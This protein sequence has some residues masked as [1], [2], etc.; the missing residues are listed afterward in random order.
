VTERTPVP[1]EHAVPRLRRLVLLVLAGVLG[2]LALTSGAARAQNTVETS[3]PED[4]GVLDES[5]AEIS[6]TFADELGE[7][8]TISLECETEL[9]TLPRPTVADDGVTLTV[10]VPEPL[11]RGTCVARWR[12]SDTDGE[13]A[14]SGAISFIVQADVPGSGPEASTPTASEPTDSTPA[15]SDGEATSGGDTTSDTGGSDEVIPLNDVDTGGGPLWLGR[16]LSWSGLAVV[17]GALVL[18]AGAW[19]EGVEYLI[20]VRFIRAMWVV[21][22]LGTLLYT[23]AATGAVNGESLGY[24]VNPANWLDLLDAGWPGRA[25]LAMLLFTILSVWV[26]LRPDRV[27]DPATQMVALAIPGLAVAMIG[28]SRTG[29]DLEV[30]GVAMGILHALAMAVWAGGVIVLARVVLAGPGEEDLVHAVRGFSRLSNGAIVLTIVTGIVQMIRLDGGNIFDSTHGRVVL[31]KAVV[32]A[33]M[34]FVAMSARQFVTRRLAR[35][36]EMTVPLAN[37]LRRAFGVEAAFGL[38]A[39]AASAWL[40]ALDPPN[41]DDSPTID[42]AIQRRFQVEEAQFDV[43]VRLTNDSVGRA[44]MEVEV[45]SPESGLSDLQVVLTAPE[46]D[47]DIGTITQPVPLPGAG[48]AVRLEQNGLPLNFPGDWTLEVSAVTPSGAVRTEPWQFTLLNADGS[49][50]TTAITLPP[51]GTVVVTVPED[52]Q[53]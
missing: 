21:A 44:G 32:V 38:L 53:E 28:V 52:T 40:L 16:V 48:V 41:V 13:P 24:G 36:N 43:T 31:L 3:S 1:D 18:I 46:N 51:S 29:G 4:G 33:A 45:D 14:G 11:G 9:V 22:L 7:A 30:L 37:R 8:N 19:P 10:E 20:T 23:M 27:I 26:V 47:P 49:V 39:I 35:A 12:V 42:Y 25:L 17:F 15:T 5:P 34:L 6:I 2:A 50:P